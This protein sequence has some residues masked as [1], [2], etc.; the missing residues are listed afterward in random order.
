MYYHELKGGKKMKN[1]LKDLN[2][3]LTELSTYLKISRPTLYKYIESFENKDYQKIDYHVLDIFKFINKRST[4]SKLSV[5]EYIINKQQ[6]SSTLMNRINEV[7][8][9]DE[10]EKAL[11]ELLHIFERDNKFEIINSIIKNYLDKD[12]DL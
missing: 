11:L 1:K 3:R 9:S 7:I 4:K 8:T 5:I 6:I 2:L 10:D 12:G